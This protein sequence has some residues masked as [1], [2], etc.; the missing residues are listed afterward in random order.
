LL[1]EIVYGGLR[2]IDKDVLNSSCYE[3]S[4]RLPIDDSWQLLGEP[5]VI[6][7]LDQ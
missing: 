5:I 2:N 1:L 3:H 6:V 4:L 7:L